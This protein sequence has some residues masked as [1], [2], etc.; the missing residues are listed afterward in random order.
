MK[1]TTAQA[2]GS[3]SSNKL[4]P[5]TMQQDSN[6]RISERSVEDGGGSYPAIS[7]SN[8][9]NYPAIKEQL[10]AFGLDS[11]TL[12]Q[13]QQVTQIAMSKMI[14]NGRPDF[15]RQLILIEPSATESVSDA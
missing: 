10:T 15:N 2:A 8:L 12:Q 11:S 7:F 13:T 3:S 4:T 5:T 6:E 1:L 14:T 9:L